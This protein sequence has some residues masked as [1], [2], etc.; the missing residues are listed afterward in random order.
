V[1]DSRVLV[2][3]DHPILRH[4]IAELVQHEPGF[5]VCAEAGSAAEALEQLARHPI[6][7]AIVDLSLAGLSG[8]D[9]L[10]TL[11]TR[12]PTVRTLVM[13]MHDET[14]YAERALR[15]GARGYVMKQEATR[16]ILTAL[17]HIRDGEIWLSE[18]MRQRLLSRIAD[19]PAAVVRQGTDLTL[20]SDR[21][22]EVFRLIGRGLKTGEIARELHRSVNT[23]EA[24]RAAIKRKFAITTGAELARL[25][26]QAFEGDA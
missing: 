20:L 3:D 18:R 5:E 2:V 10:K 22:L 25:A 4:G 12:Y 24:H 8:I 7:L 13:S 17:R 15:A 16:Q 14:L 26:F 9:L 6:D 21:E 19:A 1:P 23:V 11:R